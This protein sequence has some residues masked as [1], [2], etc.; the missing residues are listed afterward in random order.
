[1]PI[2]TILFTDIVGF[3]RESENRQ[4][5]LV[6]GLT[7]EVLYEIRDLLSPPRKASEV[8]ALPTGDGIAITFLEGDDPRG[9][10]ERIMCLAARL[11]RFAIKESIEIRLGVHYGP[12]EFICDINGKEN[13]CG[14]AINYAQRVM[15]AANGNQVLISESVFKKYLG[16][17]GKKIDLKFCSCAIDISKAMDVMAKHKRRIVVHGVEVW[18]EDRLLSTSI[19]IP[20]DSKNQAVIEL[21]PKNKPIQDDEAGKGD[22]K[23]VF[24]PRIEVATQVALIQLTGENLLPKLEGGKLTLSESLERFWVLMP[25]PDGWNCHSKPPLPDIDTLKTHVERWKNF[26][27]E[28]KKKLPKADIRLYLFKD[29]PFLG[30]SFIDWEKAQGKIHIGPYIWG[31]PAKDSPGFDLEWEN[32]HRPEVATSY[33]Q[34]MHNLMDSGKLFP[35]S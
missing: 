22:K 32:C 2:G 31:I 29:E 4:R 15:D 30:A 17:T 19:N 18:C 6:D 7:S 8:I 11:L 23:K 33:I 9:R 1:M 3:S 24:G 35:L 27:I 16:K 10:F 25:D 12:V 20:P 26:L 21:T 34:A 14:D 13:I 5:E 28:Q